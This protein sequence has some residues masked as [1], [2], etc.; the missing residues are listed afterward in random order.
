MPDDN[1]D[2]GR[3]YEFIK[4]AV[5]TPF[6]TA[7]VSRAEA[8][9]ATPFNIEPWYQTA[10]AKDQQRLAAANL[11]AWGSQNAVDHLLAKIDLYTFA[12]PLLKAK[13]KAVYGI[14]P[15]VKTTWLRLY[16]PAAT[17]WYALDLSAGAVTRTV[18]LLDA[19][20]HNFAST[21]IAGPDSQYISQPDA[22][23]LFDVLPLRHKMSIQ[24]FQTLCRE[25]DLGAQ[26]QKH[27][28][29]TLL[30]A[31]PLAESLL[32]YQVLQSQK[33]ALVVAAHMALIRGDI[34]D[35]AHKRCCAW[36]P[37]N[38]RPLAHSGRF[39]GMTCRCSTSR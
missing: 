18:S 26:Y 27:L 9:A 8:L 25:L 36:P 35:D 28:E 10:S 24:Q 13:I 34:E 39:A 31:Q 12:E 7:T 2:Q 11:K 22:R 16:I 29:G 14:E 37:A 1:P 3:H 30:P 4:S 6:K 17:P 33:D 38:S 32:R 21:E 20:L 23:D 5:S 15:D 19:A